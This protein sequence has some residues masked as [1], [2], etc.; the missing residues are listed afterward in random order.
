MKIKILSIEDDLA[1]SA[2]L[3]ESFEDEGFTVITEKDGKKGIELALNE[4]P[5]VILLDILL[6]SM[7]GFEI[8]KELRLKKIYTPI[9]M[10]SAKKEDED[11]ILGLE[12]GADDYVTKPFNIRELIARV[13]AILRRKEMVRSD[14]ESYSFDNIKIDFKRMELTKGKEKIDMTLKEFE[15]LKFFITHEGELVSRNTLLDK[16]WGYDVYPTT[17]TVDNYIMMVR[18]KIE[19]IPSHPEHLLTFH[20]AGYKFVK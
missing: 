18:K 7:S 4:E 13:N 11:K 9:I 15:I 1:V 2:G 19:K 20:S 6:P 17:R 3:K 12:L 10:L 14:M 8:C 5:D 16:V